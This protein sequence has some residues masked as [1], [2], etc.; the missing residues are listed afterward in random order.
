MKEIAWFAQLN[1]MGNEASLGNQLRVDQLKVFCFMT[2]VKDPDL[3]YKFLR[4]KEP[5]A[6]VMQLAFDLESTLSN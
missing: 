5:T 1:H 6:D 2:S 4:L 3:Q